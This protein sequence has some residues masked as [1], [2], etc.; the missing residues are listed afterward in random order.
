MGDLID[1]SRVRKQ[2]S[3]KEYREA[4]ADLHNTLSYLAK[5][6]GEMVELAAAGVSGILMGIDMG[7]YTQMSHVDVE[8]DDSGK[9][10]TR[11]AIRPNYVEFPRP[12]VEV[13]H[14]QE[15]PVV[16]LRRRFIHRDDGVNPLDCY[17]HYMKF[18]YAKAMEGGAGEATLA[19]IMVMT[20]RGVNEWLKAKADS[21]VAMH[22]RMGRL[23]LY[24]ERKGGGFLKISFDGFLRYKEGITSD[25]KTFPQ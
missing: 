16:F 3:L 25:S 20:L 1:L 21:V 15:L 14:V 13:V 23:H 8:A 5:T 12:I 22:Q 9:Y 4:V 19:G 6:D 10:M 24:V 17:H 2:R 11:F 7:C 18:R